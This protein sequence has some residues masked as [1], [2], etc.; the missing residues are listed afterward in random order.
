MTV[1]PRVVAPGRDLATGALVRPAGDSAP[2]GEHAVVIGA[3]VAGLLAARVLSDF[4]E[5]VTVL[6]RDTLPAGLT[7]RRA[8]PQGRHAHAL[9]F[10]GQNALERLLP[11]YQDE[12]VTAGAPPRAEASALRW[13]VGGHLLR[14]VDVGTKAV[15]S[16]RP[17]L[18]GLVRRRVKALSNV[19][20]RDRCDVLGLLHDNGRV[21][22]VRACD[23]APGSDEQELHADVVVAASGRGS[24]VPG[25][26]QSMGYEPPA[27]QRVQVDIMYASRHLALRP[28][29][30]GGDLIVLNG[31]KPGLPRGMALFAEEDDR[32]L[33]TLYGYG[34][35][36][37]PPTDDD[38]FNAFA[39]TV[40]DADVLSVIAQAEPLDAIT[41]HA[42]PAGVRRRYERMRRFP[43]EL[44]VIGDAICSFN[45]I[46]GQGM[47]VAAL[48]AEVLWR[49]LQDGGDRLT[50]RYFK[51]ATR[52]VEEAWKVSTGADLALPEV[53]ARA[54]LP[55]RIV[56]RYLK[57]LIS[58]AEHD[59]QLA[60]AFIKVLGMLEPPPSLM[61][62]PIVARV[63]RE[64]LRRRRRETK[65]SAKLST[66]DDAAPA[67]LERPT[68][69]AGTTTSD[70]PALTRP[71]PR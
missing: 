13:G 37:H 34:T 46:Y 40:A 54:P 10:A 4:F 69:P 19:S 1:R 48:Q 39:A 29:A 3:S 50:R 17:L 52:P 33:F 11:G 32:W 44:L 28:G 14:P 15:F 8:I 53:P 65:R 38:A 67:P 9:Q 64:S 66:A 6:E 45:P 31:P 36:H 20:L 47:T 42:Y 61:R 27:E 25:W 41:T 16:S 49:C 5:R 2:V 60:T 70:E 71:S 26:L 24:K 35:E 58:A 22:G 30:L 21:R 55:D 57:R 12:A 63:L 59:D 23:R 62:P 18:E 7:D 68:R 56:G 43:E 51:A